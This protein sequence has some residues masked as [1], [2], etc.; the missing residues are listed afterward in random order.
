MIYEPREITCRDGRSCILRSAAVTDANDLIRY[1]KVTAGETPF[2]IREPDEISLTPEQEEH[3]IEGIVKEPR[4]LMLIGTVAGEHVGNCS[5]MSLGNYERYAHRCSV[6]IALYQKYCGLG[7]GREMLKT[8]LTVAKQCG[9]EQAELEVVS[10]NTPAIRLY[11]SLGFEIWGTLLF[12]LLEI[13]KTPAIKISRNRTTAT[14]RRVCPM[15][16]PSKSPIE[17]LP[18]L[19]TNRACSIRKPISAILNTAVTINTAN[20]MQSS[21]IRFCRR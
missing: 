15:E 7:I 14:E 9:Y 11:E 6:A 13:I 17:K 20:T 21:V 19:P 8:V 3:F 1:L 16:L 2:L 18:C 10:T 5:L 4:E 12:I